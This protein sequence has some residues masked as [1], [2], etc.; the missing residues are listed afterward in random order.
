MQRREFIVAMGGAAAASASQAFAQAAVGGGGMEDM[1]PPLH[2]ALELKF[3]QSLT[4]NVLSHLHL[5]AQPALSDSL[6][7]REITL[8]DRV[9][10]S[11]Q[12]LVLQAYG[13]DRSKALLSAHRSKSLIPDNR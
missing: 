2:K 3:L 11:F 12:D 8:Q 10:D 6:T 4:Y 13:F 7:G 1:H 5:L 9:P